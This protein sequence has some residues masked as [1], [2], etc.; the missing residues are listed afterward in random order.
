MAEKFKDVRKRSK[1]QDFSYIFK[2]SREFRKINGLSFHMKE[3]KT[4]PNVL[5]KTIYW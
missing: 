3:K 1:I 4:F 5:F 2:N